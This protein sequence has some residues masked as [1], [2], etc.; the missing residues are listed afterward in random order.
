TNRA[1]RLS[2]DS[3]HSLLIF[4]AC[5][6]SVTYTCATRPS[7]RRTPCL[8]TL[9]AAGNMGSRKKL[10][11]ILVDLK[12]LSPAQVDRILLALDRRFDR[13]K[14]GEVARNMG[15][16]SEEQ[17]LAALAIQMGLFRGIE[18]WTLDEILNRLMACESPP[19]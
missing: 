2:P 1:S 14:F 9:D 13:Q 19:E 16:V 4:S 7:C 11:E 10:G 3:L 8:Q 12:V 15:L 6:E 18:D 5:R 17:V